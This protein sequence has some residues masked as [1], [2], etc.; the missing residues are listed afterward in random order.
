MRPIWSSYKT[1]IVS[2]ICYGCGI[3]LVQKNVQ[4]GVIRDIVVVEVEM[5][6]TC[7]L[8]FCKAFRIIP[9]FRR[10]KNSELAE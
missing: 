3:I 2:F 6:F 4:K 7:V 1:F 5:S 9:L 10:V 8:E